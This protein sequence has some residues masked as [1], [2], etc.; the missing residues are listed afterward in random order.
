MTLEQPL[1]GQ[2]GTLKRTVSF[3]SLLGVLRATWGKTAGWR[4]PRRD[5]SLV[6]GN[7]KWI[8][9]EKRQGGA[10]NSCDKITIILKNNGAKKAMD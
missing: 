5:Q 1:Q 6:Q 3:Q 8:T 7:E 9:V 10:R 4:Q 2:K